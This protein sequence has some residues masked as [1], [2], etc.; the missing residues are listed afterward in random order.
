MEGYNQRKNGERKKERDEKEKEKKTIQ[1]ATGKKRKRGNDAVSDVE[2]VDPPPEVEIE[3]IRLRPPPDEGVT[4][5]DLKKYIPPGTYI[6][7]DYYQGWWR[8]VIPV[9]PSIVRRWGA[10]SWKHSGVEPLQEMWSLYLDME[11][12]PLSACTVE[13]VWD[14]KFDAA[15][16]EDIILEGEGLAVQMDDG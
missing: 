11:L 1:S 4:Q 13:G 14:H 6:W 9:L 12:L 5:S 7:W 16:A 15:S 2:P 3:R 10:S 8:G